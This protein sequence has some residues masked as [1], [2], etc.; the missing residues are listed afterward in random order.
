MVSVVQRRPDRSLSVVVVGYNS[1][2]HLRRSLPPL[3]GEVVRR[4][5]EI[6]LVD[7]AS[8]D[9]TGQTLPEEFPWVRLISNRTNRGYAAGINQG[10]CATTGE[11]VLVLNPDLTVRPGCVDVLVKFMQ[12][13]PH[14]GIAAPRLLN[15]D[16]TL[17]P[18]CR[19]FH[20]LTSI[21]NRRGPL[22][23]LLAYT[24]WTARHLMLEWD[25]GAPHEVDWVLG[26][27]MLVR[28]RA[29]EDVG[30]MDEGFFL[31]F[32][33]EDWCYRMWARGWAV[34]Y[35]PFAEATHEYRRES[36]HLRSPAYRHF[37][38]SGVRLVWKYGLR[39]RRPVAST[40]EGA[41]AC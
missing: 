17:Q 31:Y 16:G 33:D 34:S 7:N 22:R 20:T 6:V 24:T 30:P 35:V 40:R 41:Q 13:H 12:A 9:L 8:T 29:I 38:R 26:A 11:L 28:R 10:I 32:E 2:E 21:L 36:D 4:G 27:C 37:V 3:E 19:R 39:M 14:V 23:S 15:P 25:H 18:S 5:G 1:L